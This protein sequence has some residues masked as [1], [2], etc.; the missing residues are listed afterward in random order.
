MMGAIM[1]NTDVLMLGW[2][3]SEYDV[4]IYSAAQKL[5]QLLYIFPALIATAFFPQLARLA[6][7]SRH[8]FISLFKQ[9]LRI[10]YMLAFPLTVG[11]ILAS[12]SIMQFLY[13]NE[14]LSA[15]TSFALLALTFIIVFPATLIVNAL[16]ALGKQKKLLAYVS[17]GVF[18]NIIFN[19]LLIPRF[20][21]E[22]SALSTI[23]TQ[24]IIN[25][26][27][28]YALRASTPFTIFGDLKKIA[29]ATLGMG[30]VTATLEAFGIPLLLTIAISAFGYV[31]LLRLLKEPMLTDALRLLKDRS[32]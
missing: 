14:Y 23:I 2:M 28:W 20:G 29:L 30:A 4:G 26:Y 5:T 12:T 21:I 3:T 9:A 1:I 31:L 15:N 13:G 8:L 17:I 18:G 7:G 27:A 11:G 6:A 25:T 19:L 24:T 22:G 32:L 16:F 10:I